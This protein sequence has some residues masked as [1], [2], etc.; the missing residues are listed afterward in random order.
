[1]FKAI[2]VS[3]DCRVVLVQ[4]VADGAEAGPGAGQVHLRRVDHMRT[5]GWQAIS[6]MAAMCY[7]SGV[8]D[9]LGYGTRPDGPFASLETATV[10]M[11]RAILTHR[12]AWY[13]QLLEDHAQEPEL[14]AALSAD[15]A[16]IQANLA[17]YD[18][19]HPAG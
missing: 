9:G 7:F 13:Q 3:E 17:A 11:D 1:M 5:E 10:W 14:V 4:E 8:A 15:L 12:I 16:R 6:E 2:R 18:A 19:A